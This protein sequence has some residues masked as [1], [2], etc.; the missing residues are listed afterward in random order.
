MSSR[1]EYR[2][3]ASSG[4]V[5]RGRVTADTRQ[6]AFNTVERLGLK[7]IELKPLVRKAKRNLFRSSTSAAQSHLLFVR[8]LSG[9]V[10]A[11]IS[12]LRAVVSLADLQTEQKDRDSI[13]SVGAA[14]RQGRQLSDALRQY[15]PDLPAYV[16]YLV[17]VGEATG[18]MT[19][20]LESATTQLERDLAVSRDIR[21]ALTYPIFL[22]IFGIAAV[23]FMF[24]VV[25]PQ[26]SAMLAKSDAK[27]PTISYVVITSGNFVRA[28]VT[29]FAVTIA[30]LVF[31]M[32]VLSRRPAVS[33]MAHRFV[34]ALPG[35][36]NAIR[37]TESARWAS[38]LAT[39]LAS[40]VTIT[41]AI[42]VANR[43]VKDTKL[44]SSLDLVDTALRRGTRLS[45]ALED[46]T[47]LDV[48]VIEMVRIG[49]QS[50]GLERM[51]SAA[52]ELLRGEADTA[53]KR[54]MTLI[55]PLSVL[56]IGASIGM[57]V[58]ALMLAICSLY[59]RVL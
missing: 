5:V 7:P 26:F 49:E 6:T 14:L 22:I 32:V 36:S 40:R 20:A 9:L 38:M 52:A 15:M 17:E 39:L 59:D 34:L 42:L 41:D 44:R 29:E 37:L 1:W 58:V 25:V 23:A 8:Q 24:A 47:S 35:I 12:M 30:A 57:I 55:E 51:L 13:T 46:F 21:S 50:G 43:I 48:R 27:L 53:L 3:H 11:G 19:F 54:F 45:D 33:E 18:E 16:S 4:K 10:A 56:V 31:L 2:A 28:H